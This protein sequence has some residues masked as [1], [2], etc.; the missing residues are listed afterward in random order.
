MVYVQN[1]RIGPIQAFT[2]LMC[3]V[4]CPNGQRT[5]PLDSSPIL[6]NHNI[7]GA[8]IW[9]TVRFAAQKRTLRNIRS[10][11]DVVAIF[12]VLLLG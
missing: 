4:R 11:N 12:R 3:R 5:I 1:P 7:F 10:A 2:D 9:L 6:N 8:A